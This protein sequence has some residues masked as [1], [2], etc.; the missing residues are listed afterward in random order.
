[1]GLTLTTFDVP[2]RTDSQGVI[3]V[4]QTRVTLDTVIG[5]FKQGAS[6]E[7]IA[8]QYPAVTLVEVYAVIAYYLQHPA[9]IDAYLREREADAEHIRRELEDQ[10]NP[11]GLREKLAARLEEKKRQ[12]KG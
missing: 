10:F 12:Q 8:S 5:A 4:G 2:L 7:T 6:P 1:M 3:R 11:V 9:E